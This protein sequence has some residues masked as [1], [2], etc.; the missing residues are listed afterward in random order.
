MKKLI[1]KLREKEKLGGIITLVVGMF[2]GA[3]IFPG[4]SYSNHDNIET[5][6]E[7]LEKQLQS[8]Q[9]E[10]N[11]KH[12]EITDKQSEIETLSA[13]VDEAK[14]FFDMK[15][16][17]QLALKAA[18]EK[19][20]EERLAKE[21]AEKIAKEK[22]ELE[23]KTVKLSNGNY[24]AGTDFEAGTYDIVAVSGNGNVSSS[25]MFSGG[26]NAVMG[27]RNSDFYEK[28]YKNI[29]LP[30]GTELT[31]DGVTINLIPKY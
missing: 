10:I 23:A 20:E 19:A 12:N 1:E 25:N 22:A 17:E 13:K 30:H 2:I 15:E 6:L 26:I 21:E 5:K 27:T 28:E 18:A 7:S 14:P 11:A 24:V 29:K 16:E 9:D 4:C 31:I 8:K 3:F